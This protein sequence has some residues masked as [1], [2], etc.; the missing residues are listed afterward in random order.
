M[1]TNATA[2]PVRVATEGTQLTEKERLL[3][4]NKAFCADVIRHYRLHGIQKTPGER[5]MLVVADLRRKWALNPD[6]LAVAEEMVDNIVGAVLEAALRALDGLRSGVE[7]ALGESR[8]VEQDTREE[9]TQRHPDYRVSIRA[10]HR[11][12]VR[13]SA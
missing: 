12:P 11:Q 6:R 2:S 13:R 1:G 4:D 5:S 10:A 9:L 8:Q 3:L 7:Y